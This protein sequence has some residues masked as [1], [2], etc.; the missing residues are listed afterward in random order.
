MKFRNAVLLAS[1]IPSFLF[2]FG[3]P[4][5]KEF[6]RIA[7]FEN[8]PRMLHYRQLPAWLQPDHLVIHRNV[9]INRSTVVPLAQASLDFRNAVVLGP[10]GKV[11]QFTVQA[12]EFA[13]DQYAF[14]GL[15]FRFNESGTTGIFQSG[16][17]FDINLVSS[18][19]EEL[20]L[21]EGSSVEL[22]YPVDKSL[23]TSE[24]KSMKAYSFDESSQ[25]WVY[26]SDVRVLKKGGK[27]YFTLKM[28]HFSYWNIDAPI[29]EHTCLEGK[30]E[31][32]GT[33]KP[34]P[35]T[36]LAEG[37]DYRGTTRIQATNGQ[38]FRLDVKRDS[39]VSILAYTAEND[40]YYLPLIQTSKELSTAMKLYEEK[41]FE[42]SSD[43]DQLKCTTNT[44]TYTNRSQNNQYTLGEYTGTG[45]YVLSILSNKTELFEWDK[46]IYTNYVFWL[47]TRAPS[48]NNS[49]VTNFHEQYLYSD[50]LLAI[51]GR[52]Q[53][54]ESA[55]NYRSDL[56]IGKWIGYYYCPLRINSK[57]L[58]L[59]GKCSSLGKLKLTKPGY[60]TLSEVFGEKKLKKAE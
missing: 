36:L 5:D 47:I 43:I 31:I 41:V 53:Q 35:V 22:T 6:M 29:T 19:G 9:D 45:G 60:K 42:V 58:L 20:R 34:L 16:G 13:S 54:N 33:A 3:P 40:G 56:R 11:S 8:D 1:M 27:Q 28:G 50:K 32:E 26:E 23:S 46:K 39:Q 48:T 7:M 37:L 4:E 57:P 17:L 2:S 25:K 49:W 51:R 30:L 55:G 18:E 15:D 10:R 44:Y 59:S 12:I 52:V 14:S 24:V 38:T 21:M